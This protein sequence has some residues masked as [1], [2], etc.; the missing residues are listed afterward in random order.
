MADPVM[1]IKN[2]LKD[3]WDADN[4]SSV[5]PSFSTGWYDYK[6]TSPQITITDP[7]ENALSSGPTGY[8]GITTGGVPA[9]YWLGS[10]D[11]NV[12][13]TREGQAINPKLL[14]SQFVAEI[15][16]LIRANY[17]DVT[18]LDSIV[19]RGGH[20]SVEA[21]KKPAVYRYAGTVGFGYLD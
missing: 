4:T 21:D 14:R 8:F 12:W 6:T 5:T 17:D 11:I 7:E 20:G 18:D 10:V 15:K 13:L 19:W 3:N 1:G 16:R 9:Q 2:V